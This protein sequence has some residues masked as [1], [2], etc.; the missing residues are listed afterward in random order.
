MIVGRVTGLVAGLHVAGVGGTSQRRRRGPC[1]VDLMCHA[2]LVGQHAAACAPGV[3]AGDVQRAAGIVVAC[4]SS[5]LGLAGI[6]PLEHAVARDAAVE[7]GRQRGHLQVLVGGDEAS[8]VA[9]SSLP[10]REGHHVAA[11]QAE[12]AYAVVEL[13]VREGVHVSACV[14]QSEVTARLSFEVLFGV[15]GEGLEV[16][17]IGQ[18]DRAAVVHL[19]LA[20]GVVHG[21]LAVYQH[22]LGKQ[23]GSFRGFHSCEYQHGMVGVLDV[24]RAFAGEGRR[25]GDDEVGVIAQRDSRCHLFYGLFRIRG[26]QLCRQQQCQDHC[27]ASLDSFHTWNKVNS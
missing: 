8:A 13:L 23:A 4:C 7:D 5:Q 20:V 15:D 3:G 11:L 17:G 26:P 21:F 12:G 6:V 10:E 18:D 14:L 16:L 27:D 9:A 22:I 19:Q 25:R 24:H 1:G 2:L